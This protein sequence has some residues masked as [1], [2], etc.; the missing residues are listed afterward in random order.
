MRI[1]RLT[2]L[3]IL[4]ILLLTPKPVTCDEASR[5]PIWLIHDWRGKDVNYLRNYRTMDSKFHAIKGG[6]KTPSRAG[7]SSLNI[8]GSAQFGRMSLES[9]KTGLQSYSMIIVDLRQESH[10]FVNGLPVSWYQGRDQMNWG[11]S[12]EEI[13]AGEKGRLAAL[14]KARTIK[15][16]TLTQPKDPP[17]L[18]KGADPMTVKV[19]TV[20]T[21][22]ELCEELGIFY[23]RMPVP[24]Y[25][26]PSGRQVDR[27]IKLA[28]ASGKNTWIHVHCEAGDGRTTAFLTMYDMMHNARTVSFEDIVH[29][30]WLLGGIDLMATNARAPWKREY[31]RKRAEFIKKFYHYCREN[32]DG[33]KTTWPAWLEGKTRLAHAASLPPE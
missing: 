29:R 19:H 11:R 23:M 21:E 9:I 5:L 15:V 33:F 18:K 2:V 28:R 24:D 6:P 20:S 31:A 14:F 12:I 26:R 27:F 16:Y 22:R 7:L 13:E 32:R 8:S 10:G 1:N 17:A 3:L 4:S 30:Q 25:M